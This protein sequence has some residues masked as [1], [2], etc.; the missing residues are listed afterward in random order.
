MK[1]DEK[2]E[3]NLQRRE[4]REHLGLSTADDPPQHYST[5]LTTPPLSGSPFSFVFLS[6][7]PGV[8]G[9]EGFG[10]A[11]WGYGRCLPPPLGSHREGCFDAWGTAGG[12]CVLG[13]GFL[14]FPVFFSSL[15]THPLAP[16]PLLGHVSLHGYLVVSFCLIFCLFLVL[17]LVIVLTVV[18][19]SVRSVTHFKCR[20]H[21]LLTPFC[22]GFFFS[23]CCLSLLLFSFVSS[24]QHSAAVSPP[25]QRWGLGIFWPAGSEKDIQGGDLGLPG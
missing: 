10:L 2:R 16:F 21:Y 4:A 1:Y 3:R 6:F 15:H 5:L 17:F 11:R 9:V 19:Y 8:P 7:F 20:R 13:A 25:I 12:L 22:V 23:F 24:H 14:C 18:V